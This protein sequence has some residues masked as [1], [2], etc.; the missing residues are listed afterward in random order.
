METPNQHP[1]QLP[2]VANPT[3][4]EKLANSI[5]V[6]F[7]VIMVLILLLLIPMSWVSDLIQERRGREEVVSREI[8]SKWG[9][10]QVLSG[11]VMAIPYDFTYSTTAIDQ[12]KKEIIQLVE[13]REWIFVLPDNLNIQSEVTPEPLK[14][15]IYQAVV[16][17][18]NVKMQGD[19]KEL[20]LAKVNSK[21][22]EIRW[23]EARL[24]FGISDV[25]GLNSFPKLKM[26]DKNLEL[27]NDDKSLILFERNLSAAINLTAVA[28]VKQ[29]FAI[30][31]LLKGSKSL[32]FFPLANQTNI[33]VSGKWENP[34]F[35]GAFL[36]EDRSLQK[37]SFDATWRIPNFTRKLPQQWQGE[38]QRL[39]YFS[40]VF[41]NDE[42]TS[43]DATSVD[44]PEPKSASGEFQIEQSRDADMI[45]VN[46]LPEV[47][48]YQK[49]TRVAKYG[50]LVIVLTFASL[51]F[52]ELI[53]KQR[54]HIIQYV[55]IGMAMVL[56]YSLLLAFSEHFGFNAAYLIAAIAT[57]FLIASFIWGITK[58]KKT[59]LLFVGVLTAFYGFIF[60]L[61]QLR[62]FSLL[63]G[64]IGIF[65]ILAIIMRIATKVNWY[66]FEQKNRV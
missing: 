40:G 53:K 31:V 38:S 3:F 42:T 45:Q 29:K 13:A 50:I 30:E 26:G 14:R 17:N 56:F 22:G 11:P 39:Y 62:D 47:N 20:D 52:T 35:N 46:F 64:T 32:N 55:L 8:A 12:N 15:G 1:P 54:I 33:H 63:V 61:M 27:T 5:A 37:G 24:V 21:G 19:F 49:T 44:I 48:N 51:F 34:S 66:Q 36:P 10:E 4:F 18:T 59:A 58:D 9:Q 43:Y 57:I 2:V 65:I 41:L 6:K 16:Y 7:A 60:T 28:D 25:K 23:A